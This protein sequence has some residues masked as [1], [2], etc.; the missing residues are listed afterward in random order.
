ME[1]LN[2]DKIFLNNDISNN[3]QQNI[4]AREEIDVNKLFGCCLVALFIII[5]I[6]FP[7]NIFTLL[8]IIPY[9]RK[10]VIDEVRKTLV[11]FMQGII[12]CCPTGQRLYNLN[13]IEKIRLFITSKPDP[14][15]G[16]NKLYFIN[17]EIYS[18]EGEKNALFMDIPYEEAKYKQFIS[19]F[20][21][22]LNTEFDPLEII[23]NTLPK[24][25]DLVNIANSENENKMIDKPL[26]DGSFAIPISS[27]ITP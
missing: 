16:F 11:I 17:C 21:R 12:G 2:N 25:N 6:I 8:I 26:I 20:Q 4:I 5:S 10:I 14:K 18:L 7:F 1:T 24:E 15:V 27:A 19:F 13:Q 3:N 9:K 22:H 23:F